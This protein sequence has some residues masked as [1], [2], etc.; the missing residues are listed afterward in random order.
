M[1]TDTVGEALLLLSKVT[2]NL[3][4]KVNKLE[5]SVNKTAG[6]S[7]DVEPKRLVKKSEPV[8]VTNFGRAAEK[9]LKNA[10]SST[11]D[12][13]SNDPM[14]NGGMGF[15]KKLLG[16]GLVILGGLSALVGGLLNDGPLRGLL[17]IISKAGLEFGVK[18]FA[19][20]FDSLIKSAKGFLGNVGKFLLAPFKKIAGQGGAKGLFGSIGKLFT[21]FL[22]PVLKRIP[23]IGSLISW[24]FA[25]S[26]FKS[27]Q[28]VRGLIDVASGIATLFPGIGTGIGIGLDVLNAFLDIKGGQ[29]EVKPAGSGFKLSEFFSKIQDKIMNNFPMKNLLSFTTG[30]GK[31]IKGDIKGGL[32]DIAYT[33]PFVESIT[34]LL[35]DSREVSTDKE[36]NFSFGTFFKTIKES[37]LEKLIFLFPKTFGIRQQVGKLLGIDV[38]GNGGEGIPDFSEQ[39]IQNPDGSYVNYSDLGDADKKKIHGRV[40]GGPIQ[41]GNEY[42]VGEKGPEIIVPDSDGFVVNNNKSLD[43]LDKKTY[44]QVANNN[45]KLSNMS[46]S[47]LVKNNNLLN[48]ILNKVNSGNTIVNN[49]NSSTLNTG[50][51]NLVKS[52]RESYA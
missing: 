29:E 51:N 12:I 42:L 22:K 35:S 11:S 38:G 20:T 47:E 46:Y 32:K 21:K 50:N 6:G 9:D 26:R 4:K 3:D 37:I 1:A 27:G 17:K 40:K 39:K 16:P 30:I 7:P 15:M 41:Q 33:I 36:G 18:A 34:S 14:K 23:G 24:S 44:I 49:N 52:F 31:V 10:F 43:I 28:L 48:Q 13:D 19:K 5:K 45:L 25:V 2:F 8:V